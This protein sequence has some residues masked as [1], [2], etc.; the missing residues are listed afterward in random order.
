MME[1]EEVHMSD[2]M[3][4]ETQIIDALREYREA[5]NAKQPPARA[6]TSI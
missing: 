2:Q 6:A 3:G 1:T 5:H 4:T